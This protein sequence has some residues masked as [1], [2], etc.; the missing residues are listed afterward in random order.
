MKFTV[1]QPNYPDQ[2]RPVPFSIYGEN[3]A[4]VALCIAI[5]KPN[6]CSIS[7][8]FRGWSSD[9]EL[10]PAEL[11]QLAA[12]MLAAAEHIEGAAS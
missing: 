5:S 3:G 9:I 2:L 10:A 11:R 8:S 6:V 7:T 12:Q 4:R 1:I